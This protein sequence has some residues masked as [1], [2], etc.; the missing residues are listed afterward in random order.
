MPIYGLRVSYRDYRCDCCDH[1]HPVQTNHTGL[2]YDHCPNCSWRYGRDSQG[3]TY[4]ADTEKRRP[5]YYVGPEPTEAEHN[6]YARREV[7]GL[8]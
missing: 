1:T 2:I 8:G 5:H 6:P 4:R 3:T 7:N